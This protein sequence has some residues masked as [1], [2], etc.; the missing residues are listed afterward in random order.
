MQLSGHVQHSPPFAHPLMDRC[1]SVQRD[2]C[3]IIN[4]T[5]S[6][7]PLVCARCSCQVRASCALSETPG[8][9][10][11]AVSHLPQSG[12]RRWASYNDTDDPLQ[13]PIVFMTNF[14]LNNSSIT[15]SNGWLSLATGAGKCLL[16]PVLMK[17]PEKLQVHVN[18]AAPEVDFQSPRLGL[19]RPCYT[20]AQPSKALL[21]LTYG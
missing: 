18:E 9:G 7:V 21:V 20:S 3:R 6:I 12:G 11:N 14:I 15:A 4:F 1:G 17:I 10:W 13:R 5:S 8:L 2:V 19:D 16:Q